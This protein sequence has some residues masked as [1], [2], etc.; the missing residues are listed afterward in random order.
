VTGH[1]WLDDLDEVVEDVASWLYV[2]SRIV[3]KLLDI[4]R[5]SRALELD[6][7]TAGRLPDERERELLVLGDSE[8]K[9]PDELVELFPAT[10]AFLESLF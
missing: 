9:C 1:T 5:L 4:E 3:L 8:G 2:D 10:N 6:F 7:E